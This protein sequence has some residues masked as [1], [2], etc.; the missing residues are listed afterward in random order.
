MDLLDQ[1]NEEQRKIVA[2][3]DK[4]II[5]LSG[6]GTG[7]TRVL[8]SK[9]AHDIASGAD[10]HKVMA[11]TF[12]NKA[13]KEIKDRLFR[14]LGNSSDINAGTFHSI[15]YKY[16][17]KYYNYLGFNKQP[18]V[19][20]ET[21]QAKLVGEIQ[22][23]YAKSGM[24]PE[25]I[26]STFSS[27]RRICKDINEMRRVAKQNRLPNEVIDIY[28]KYIDKKKKHNYVDFDD[29]LYF[30]V[31]LLK[32]RNVRDQ[33]KKTVE[34]L[35]VD[36]FQD[37]NEI[38]YEFINLIYRDDKNIFV[39]GDDAQSIYGWNGSDPK[40]MHRFIRDY[41]PVKFAMEQNYRSTPGI[42]NV[43][44][45][46]I[47][48]NTKQLPK[49][50]WTSKGNNEKVG[51]YG[52]KESYTEAIWISNQ[53][54]HLS[55]KYNYSDMAVLCRT[56]YQTIDVQK[57][58]IR[59]RIPFKVLGTSILDRIEIKDT[60]AYLRLAANYEDDLAFKRIINV[61]NRKIGK[62]TI[63]K[64]FELAKANEM[65]A[66]NYLLSDLPPKDIVKKTSNFV[67]IIESIADIIEN[68]DI[69][70]IIDYV[71][72]TVGYR[73]YVAKK[74]KED[75]K[76]DMFK[77]L[78][79]YAKSFDDVI[80]FIFSLSSYTSED[81]EEDDVV[82]IMTMHSAKGLEFK[83]VFIPGVEEGLLPHA[84]CYTE[85]EIE[86]ERRLF[87]VGITRAQELLYLS[88]SISRKIY[89]TATQSKPSRFLS[90][91]P[92]NLFTDVTKKEK[93]LI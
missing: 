33:I 6:A 13:A 68:D 58:L 59:A 4:R 47:K 48:H 5:A 38:Q 41:K 52:F 65:S 55:R 71:W 30:M 36:E 18:T 20:D 42:L 77:E 80:Q 12:T 60:S 35:Y 43:A 89:G 46:L 3:K 39:V 21:D 73:D 78:K 23:E 28:A 10:P 31:K 26:I 86:E 15:S 9:I 87:Y 82:K 69:I 84:N 67:D 32:D 1:L 8:T 83:V 70:G 34:Y 27:Y 57:V 2:S 75:A 7:K 37:I 14:L 74:R 63:E 24:N 76:I 16:V 93:L 11:I 79:D 25:A 40:I 72:D 50:L 85:D 90:E 29:L 53:I 54:K 91:V 49:N 56:N 22:K 66:F 17:R 19:I 61:P 64:I 92:Q 62:K 81:G 45:E 51:L 88:Y 44:N